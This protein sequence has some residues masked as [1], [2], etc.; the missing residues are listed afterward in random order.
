MEP[1]KIKNLSK[2][3][4]VIQT[5]KNQ[6]NLNFIFSPTSTL[7]TNVFTSIFPFFHIQ[8]LKKLLSDTKNSSRTRTVKQ[9]GQNSSHPERQAEISKKLKKKIENFKSSNSNDTT[10]DISKPAVLL[11]KISQLKLT[12]SPQSELLEIDPYEEF[13]KENIK[14]SAVQLMYSTPRRDKEKIRIENTINSRNNKIYDENRQFLA[15]STQLIR[16]I[17]E[18][19]N[20]ITKTQ[21]ENQ[22]LQSEI[23]LLRKTQFPENLVKSK[24]NYK[25]IRI[26][27]D[28]EKVK[29]IITHLQS[30]N[31]SSKK[32]TMIQ[33]YKKFEMIKTPPDTVSFNKKL[34]FSQN[35]SNTEGTFNIRSKKFTVIP[36]SEKHKENKHFIFPNDIKNSV[37]PI[38]IAVQD[39]ESWIQK[40]RNSLTEFNE[41]FPLNKKKIKCEYKGN[42]GAA[43]LKLKEKIVKLVKIA[44]NQHKIILNF[45]NKAK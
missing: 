2:I 27:Q 28:K 4:T 14:N 20:K 31:N 37:E 35:I 43:L 30:L 33:N 13:K 15:Q 34:L 7:P 38:K 5:P 29:N 12:I 39:K 42:F 36:K 41:T 23:D 25:N 26:R 10:K 6:R 21:T 45:N 19:D 32:R 44:E 11:N 3:K 9:S 8:G 17:D 18:K 1:Q 40:L 24:P 16:I 22:N